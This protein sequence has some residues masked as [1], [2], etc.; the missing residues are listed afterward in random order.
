MKKPIASS[1]AGSTPL[2][3]TIEKLVYGGDGLAR[4]QAPAGA[5]G[6]RGKTVL[7]PD[8]LPGERVRIVLEEESRSWARGRVV[9]RLAD[10]PERIT[11]GC[12][13]FGRCG[14]CQ[15]QYAG[16]ETQ[17]EWKE[18]IL[19]ETLRRTGR[20]DWTGPVSR[21][22]AAP[23]EYRSRVRL[24]FVRA[25]SGGE[26]EAALQVGY[27]ER[28]SHRLLP[29]THCPIA[30]PRI[31]E[32][33][34]AL[35][36]LS[37]PPATAREVELSVD[38]DDR[39]LTALFIF[40]QATVAEQMYAATAAASLPTGASVA[41]T[42]PDAGPQVVAGDGFLTNAVGAHQ[43]HVSA[44]A[45]FQVNRFLVQQ[46]VEAVTAGQQGKL[47]PNKLAIDLFAGVGLFTVPL[48][49]SF[50]RVIAVEV[51]PT[52]VEDLRR[53]TLALAGVEV[54]GR[55]VADWLRRRGANESPDLVV[56]DPPRT[57][58]G[59]VVT[60]WLVARRPA[61]IH[62]VSCDPATLAR[63]LQP[64]LAAGYAIEQLHLFDLFPQ[65]YHIET[66]VHLARKD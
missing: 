23:W 9:E 6:G 3:V 26:G 8:V 48:A 35:T 50:E 10:A 63:D 57:G 29:V 47:A 13:Y 2:D 12:E 22:A 20:I 24:R 18:Q 44:G 16:A 21:H 61:R 52:A 43:Y 54:S 46:M 34:R 37:A 11:P 31:N 42:E 17:L 30:S 62:A 25:A 4:L 51:H 19:R 64:L 36:Q 58:L 7:I 5:E 49:Q 66:V 27:Y 59:T 15:W 65:T 53:N 33:I 60:D 55:P 39:H 1:R 38:L 40:E 56:A 41:I 14:G 32:A 28:N 45:F